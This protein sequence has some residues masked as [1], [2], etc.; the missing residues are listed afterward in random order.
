MSVN[1]S[2][3]Q[4]AGELQQKPK[5]GAKPQPTYKPVCVLCNATRSLT[6]VRTPSPFGRDVYACQRHLGS[7]GVTG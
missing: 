5:G 1:I 7:L 2:V 6:L 3:L 4:K